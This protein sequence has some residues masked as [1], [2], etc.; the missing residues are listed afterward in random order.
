MILIFTIKNDYSSTCIIRLLNHLGRKVVRIN[1]DDDTYKF[2]R[3]TNAG[4]FF[5]NTITNEIVNLKEARACWWRKSGISKRHFNKRITNNL[6]T[7]KG[8]DLS[9]FMDE[10][11]NYLNNEYNAL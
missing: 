9:H 3:I 10:N 8:L 2:D 5:R 4:V 1:G 6:N 7:K 11:S